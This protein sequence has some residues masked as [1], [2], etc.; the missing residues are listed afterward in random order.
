MLGTRTKAAFTDDLAPLPLDNSRGNGLSRTGGPKVYQNGQAA[1]KYGFRRIRGKGRCHFIFP[2]DHFCKLAV[3]NKDICHIRSLY[4][5][6]RSDTAKIENDLRCTLLCQAC[7]L[8]ANVIGLAIL[9]AEHLD[10]AD[11]SGFHA[12]F[13][14]RHLVCAARG[15][16][17]LRLFAGTQHTQ[18]YGCSGITAHHLAGII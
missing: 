15:L 12:G 8:R 13:S 14:G 10:D 2:A 7:H 18:T 6:S 5:V 11:L 1:V 9:K 3:L 17:R 16:Y 4:Q